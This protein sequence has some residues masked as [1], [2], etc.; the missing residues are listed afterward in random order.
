MFKLKF[1]FFFLL[2]KEKILF[3]M[4]LFLHLPNKMDV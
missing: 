1:F 2:Q 4:S 3:S